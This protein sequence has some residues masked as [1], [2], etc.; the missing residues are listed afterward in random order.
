MLITLQDTCSIPIGLQE[1]LSHEC[2]SLAAVLPL[3]QINVSQSIS[4][5]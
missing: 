5:L 4:Q 3:T 2:L 1:L